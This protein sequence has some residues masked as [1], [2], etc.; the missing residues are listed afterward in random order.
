MSAQE[1]AAQATHG[2]A[3]AVSHGGGHAASQGFNAGDYAALVRA[4]RANATYA[5]MH[6]AKFPN[7]E[8]RGQIKG[9]G[10]GGDD[11]DDD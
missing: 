7:G 10:G 1:H 9:G 4:I 3:E 8:I 2:A 6:T 5:N 11:D